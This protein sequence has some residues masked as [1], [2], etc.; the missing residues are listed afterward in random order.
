MK[1]NIM[2]GVFGFMLVLGACGGGDE[3]SGG[4]GDDRSEGAELYTQNCSTCHGGNLQG[5]SGP[6]L[7]NVGEKYDVD[8][9][10]DIAQNGKGGM[11]AQNIT[12]E[13]ATTIAEWI[14][15]RGS[16]EGE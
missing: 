4:G 16:G 7:E 15:S 2:V 12:E 10:V 11:P 5:G 8:T 14:T 13:E 3:E 9:I 6:N 1:R